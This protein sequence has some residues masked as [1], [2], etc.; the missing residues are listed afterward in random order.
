MATSWT[1]YVG[2]PL[3]FE[4]DHPAGGHFAAYEVAPNLAGVVPLFSGIPL[5]AA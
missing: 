5:F 3:V 1:P 2:S 4:V